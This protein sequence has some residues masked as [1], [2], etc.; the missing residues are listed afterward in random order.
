[1]DKTAQ[2]VSRHG[3]DAVFRRRR[4]RGLRRA[5]IFSRILAERQHRPGGP[6]ADAMGLFLFLSADGHRQP[7]HALGQP[8]DALRLQRGDERAI[9]H[10]PRPD[11][12]VRSQDKAICAGAI[13]AYKQIRDVDRNWAICTGWKIRMNNFRGAL[14]FVSPDRDARR[15]V[16]VSIER[17]SEIAG[18]SARAGSGEKLYDPRTE[19]RAR[20]RRDAAGRQNFHRRGIDARRH[21]AFLRARRGS[22]RHRIEFVVIDFEPFPR[23]PCGL[24]VRTVKTI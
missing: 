3:T 21:R 7:R 20:T 4:P 15:G 11:K 19:S 17:R 23:L 1:M 10:G 14:N 2:D 8:A 16:C 6:R 5:E 12:I 18:A 24:L 9:W 22:L 13:S